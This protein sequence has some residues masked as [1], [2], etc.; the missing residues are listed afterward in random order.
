MQ[1]EES[2]KGNTSNEKGLCIYN[3]GNIKERGMPN[4]RSRPYSLGL[5]IGLVLLDYIEF[6]MEIL[7]RSTICQLPNSKPGG[8]GCT[9]SGRS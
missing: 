4:K 2:V 7:G 8:H 6:V 1:I 3:C 5:A 9:Q